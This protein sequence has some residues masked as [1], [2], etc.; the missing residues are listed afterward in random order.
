MDTAL[1]KQQLL[2]WETVPFE[3]EKEKYFRYAAFRIKLNKITK[4]NPDRVQEV[5]SFLKTE[6][7]DVVVNLVKLIESNDETI[8]AE[9]L[10]AATVISDRNLKGLTKKEIAEAEKVANAIWKRAVF[11]ESYHEAL[12]D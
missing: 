10:E 2:S 8:L 3:Q 9:L 4:R 7:G 6:K 11:E 5:I 12:G 1:L